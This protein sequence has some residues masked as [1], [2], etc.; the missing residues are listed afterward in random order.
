MSKRAGVLAIQGDF[1][2]H[3]RILE[4]AASDEGPP[5]DRV[6]SQRR[7]KPC[8]DVIGCDELSLSVTSS[9]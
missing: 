4:A 5:V 3:R 2:A 7:W 1:D 8:G 9:M 6:D